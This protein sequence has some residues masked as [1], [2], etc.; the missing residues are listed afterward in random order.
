M[1]IIKSYKITKFCQYTE[2]EVIGSCEGLTYDAL[3]AYMSKEGNIC[4][5]YTWLSDNT[6]EGWEIRKFQ[7]K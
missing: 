3:P 1:E 4:T 5:T 7:V 6:G 2:V